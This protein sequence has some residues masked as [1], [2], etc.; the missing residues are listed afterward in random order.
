MKITEKDRME[1]V[2]V[3]MSKVREAFICP[4]LLNVS[5]H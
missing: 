2:Q 1:K 3:L 4:L 5:R